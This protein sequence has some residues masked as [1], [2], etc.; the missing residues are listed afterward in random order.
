M[1][2][3][4]V[5]SLK[6]QPF[7]A[8]LILGLLGSLALYGFLGWYPAFRELAAA[9]QEHERL[10][11]RLRNMET[12]LQPHA[13]LTSIMDQSRK[14]DTGSLVL[15][16]PE[17]LQGDLASRV[18]AIFQESAR[19]VGVNLKG[20]FP[21]ANAYDPATGI[22]PLRMVAAGELEALHGFLLALGAMPFVETLLSLDMAPSGSQREMVLRMS[23]RTGKEG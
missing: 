11:D 20:V 10:Q 18:D 14:V 21:D 9:R 3:T 6:I 12:L 19:N 16:A 23:V 8:V 13:V 2:V 17:I 1:K 15:P 5:K 7:N 4:A 22:L